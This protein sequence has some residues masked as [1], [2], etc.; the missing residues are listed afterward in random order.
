[1][2]EARPDTSQDAAEIATRLHSAAIH[3]L[4][5]L[6]REDEAGALSAPQLSA[7]SVIVHAGPLS[8]AEL[9][10][11][12]QVRPA[13]MSV[14]VSALTGAGLAERRTSTRDRRAVAIAAT[15]AGRAV[16]EQ[17]RQRRTRVLEQEIAALGP[18]AHAS[19]AGILPVLERL[20]R[21]A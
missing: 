3:L 2:T 13:S 10:R 4:R 16:L 20:A 6:R 14:T 5:R 8:L 17:G 21:G 7:L 18:D 15:P 11:T 9:A 19:L 1:M 12:E